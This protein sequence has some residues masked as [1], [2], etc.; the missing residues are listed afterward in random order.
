MITPIYTAILALLFVFLSIRVIR[1]RRKQQISIG[2]NDDLTL[3]R[4]IRVHA[5]FSE[6]VPLCLLS[7]YMLESMQVNNWLIHALGIMLITGRLL[8][9]HG[10][11]K[12]TED[13]RFRVTGMAL[14]FTVLGIS[15]VLLLLFT[16]L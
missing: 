5:N 11:S 13:Y 2:L 8:H 4:A 16:A 9:A 14:S 1:L 15:A 10:V 3:T 7:I 12:T 6:Y